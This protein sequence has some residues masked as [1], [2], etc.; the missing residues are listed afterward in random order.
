L[1]EDA[2]PPEWKCQDSCLSYN[3]N[4]NQICGET[5]HFTS[6]AILLGSGVGCG[7]GEDEEVQT[8]ISWLSLA[9]IIVAV[10]CII[11]GI[12][13]MELYMLLVRKKQDKKRA[14]RARRRKSK[15]INSLKKDATSS[16]TL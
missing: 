7:D 5:G 14:H 3:G 8:I 1:D 13:A 11:L 2:N 16:T 9:A 6:F 15:L 12:V 4:G 10:I